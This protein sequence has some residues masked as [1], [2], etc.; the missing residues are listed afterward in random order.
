MLV[1][2]KR[3]GYQLSS[4]YFLLSVDQ[5]KYNAIQNSSPSIYDILIQKVPIHEIV[6]VLM[7]AMEEKRSDFH[8]CKNHYAF[9]CTIIQCDLTSLNSVFY[10]N[11]LNIPGVIFL[12]S[13]N[14]LLKLLVL[15]GLKNSLP[16]IIFP[17]CP[18]LH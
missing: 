11:A 4:F 15:N 6:L 17:Y 10:K 16:R 7:V 18:A 2:Q 8:F 13:Q 9:F 5:T 1:L 14:K 3:T 12:F